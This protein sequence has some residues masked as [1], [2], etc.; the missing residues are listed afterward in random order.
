MLLHHLVLVVFGVGLVGLCTPLTIRNDKLLVDD[1][2]NRMPLSDSHLLQVTGKSYFLYGAVYTTCDTPNS[3]NVTCPQCAWHNTRFAAYSSHDMSPGSWHLESEDI[4]PDRGEWPMTN[5]TYFS[6]SVIYN[7]K[8]RTY[9][10]WMLADVVPGAPHR[11][12]P[13]NP[14][15]HSAASATSKN[16]AGPFRIHKPQWA[17]ANST[18]ATT[19][20]YPWVG[21]D[22]T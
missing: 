19:D 6:P 5:T 22:G 10:L 15:K 7:E 4:F 17:L 16:P 2:G 14:K 9:V 13:G 21:P 12:E 11:H 18:P 8:T 1:A 20:V 3:A